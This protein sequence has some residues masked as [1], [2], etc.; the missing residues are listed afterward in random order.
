MGVERLPLQGRYLQLVNPTHVHFKDN[1][2]FNQDELELMGYHHSMINWYAPDQNIKK[3]GTHI[4]L[5]A[6][7]AVDDESLG[8]LCNTIQQ[9]AKRHNSQIANIW[10]Q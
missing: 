1:G 6:K 2:R 8:A 4:Q 3:P 10:V 9:E 5:A 7:V